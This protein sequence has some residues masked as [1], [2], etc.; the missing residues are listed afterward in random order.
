MSETLL[1]LEDD[2]EMHL[3]YEKYL[4]G[5]FEL[6]ICQTIQLAYEVLLD[7]TPL[8]FII[9]ETLPDGS[10][11]DFAHKIRNKERFVDTPIFVLTS[12]KELS[13]KLLAF[14][15]GVDDYLT[16]PIEPLELQARVLSKIKTLERK[17]SQLV[18]HDLI[19]DKNRF[20]ASRL[21]GD[22]SLNIDLSPREFE[23]LFH[24]AKH[25]ETVHPREQLLELFWQDTKEGLSDRCVDKAI[26]RLRTKLAESDLT[27]K[28]TYGQG[29]SLSKK[30]V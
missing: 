27:I 8:L 23:L 6:V 1:I 18:I 29:Y 4:R 3:I 14:S 2:P 19:L 11:I 21:S 7:L 12:T 16:K 25:Q 13:S 24:L 9:D 30:A 10:G 20:Q 26:S 5:D 22:G 28:T 17:T 15:A